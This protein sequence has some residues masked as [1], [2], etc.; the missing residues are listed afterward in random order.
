MFRKLDSLPLGGP[1]TLRFAK[2]PP[3]HPTTG[4]HI[5]RPNRW[6]RQ[7][8]QPPF[9]RFGMERRRKL[10]LLFCQP[11]CLRLERNILRRDGCPHPCRRILFDTRAAAMKPLPRFAEAGK[12]VRTGHSRAAVSGHRLPFGLRSTEQSQ[13]SGNRR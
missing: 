1:P 4:P 13:S 9:H 10:S 5:E 8:T 2:N 7:C 6:S 3:T 11:G 12:A